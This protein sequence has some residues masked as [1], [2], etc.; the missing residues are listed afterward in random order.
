M[1]PTGDYWYLAAVVFWSLVALGALLAIVIM[2]IRGSWAIIA[3]WWLARTRRNVAVRVVAK[4]Q[5]TERFG[6]ADAPAAQRCRTDWFVTF[7]FGDGISLELKASEDVYRSV[8]QGDAGLLTH[9]GRWVTAFVPVSEPW[10]LPPKG[11]PEPGR[12]P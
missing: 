8:E 12:E 2:V 6:P 5:D 4:R 3:P 10:G 7:A 11:L 1:E 9:D